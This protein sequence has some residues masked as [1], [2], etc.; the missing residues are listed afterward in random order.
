MIESSAD[1]HDNEESVLT[2][3]DGVITIMQWNI[4]HFSQGKSKQSSITD[5]SFDSIIE[6]YRRLIK[7]ANASI[8]SLNEYSVLFANTPLHPKCSADSALF[9]GYTYSGIGNNALQRNY[10]LNAIFSQEEI[11]M[12]QTIEYETNYDVNIISNTAV[13]ATDY[14]YL[15]SVIP[16]FGEEIAF[17][18]THL[19]FDKDQPSLTTNQIRELILKMEGY[20]HIIICG[21][22]N[23]EPDDYKLFT[24]SGYTLANKGDIKTYPS[25]KPEKALDNIIAKGVNI[26]NVRVIH[27]SL[28]DHLPLLCDLTIIPNETVTP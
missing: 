27:S 25:S 6:K 2:N 5:S 3:R 8:L 20:D 10:S 16:L 18:S 24:K 13:R 19:A 11:T 7:S 9:S 15:I 23:A 28:S 22:F 26:S 1:S 4:G 14:Y 17:L 21:D 12:F